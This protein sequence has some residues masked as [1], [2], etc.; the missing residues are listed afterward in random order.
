MTKPRGPPDL[1]KIIAQSKDFPDFVHRA[2]MVYG[3]SK[4]ELG[5]RMYPEENPR[6]WSGYIHDVESR[7][8]PPSK[9]FVAGVCKA[10]T[11]GYGP[12]LP[13]MTATLL[14]PYYSEFKKRKIP[15]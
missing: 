10:L 13:L 2:R 3:W 8:W 5:K 7:Q 4:Y 9:K 1:E 15:Y 11:L 6:S 14:K 12:L